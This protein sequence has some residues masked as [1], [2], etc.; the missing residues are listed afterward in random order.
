MTTI[1]EN[2]N[3]FEENNSPLIIKGEKKMKDGEILKYKTLNTLLDKSEK[4]ICEI[5]SEWEW[6]WVFLYNKIS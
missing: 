3:S 6:N 4:S 5:K 2:E 1:N